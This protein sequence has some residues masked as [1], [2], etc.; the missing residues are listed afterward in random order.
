MV[1]GFIGALIS[2]VVL[3]AAGGV[4][5]A[6]FGTNEPVYTEYVE[7]LE[8]FGEN[9]RLLDES[10]TGERTWNFDGVDEIREVEVTSSG[11]KTYIE[12]SKNGKLQVT[13][14]S[15]GWNELSVE[16]EYTPG[17]SLRLSVSRVGIGLGS[18]GTVTICVP[19][20][21]YERMTIAVG[22][23]T[24]EARDIKARHNEF[25]VSS[26]S[27]EFAQSPRFTADEL[28]LDLGSGSVSIA[29]AAT[30]LYDVNMGSG[31]FD[32]SGLTGDGAVYIGSGSGTVE[33][34]KLEMSHNL[35]ELGSGSLKVYIPNDTKADLYTSFGSGS[36]YID[37]CGVSERVT[38]DRQIKLNGGSNDLVSLHAE[39][40]SGRLEL[41]DSSE[42]SSPNMFADFPAA[43][44]M[45]G[46]VVTDNDNASG[47]VS[48]DTN[49]AEVTTQ[50]SVMPSDGDS[51]AMV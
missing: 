50:S 12:P 9:G 16:V 22:S 41:R 5:V 30:T 45:P 2:A 32:I 38:D 35:F 4:T 34:A 48:A 7:D 25:N 15:S 1:K 47:F 49:I 20:A 40:G 23:G 44:T 28:K 18:G 43:Q 14:Q 21:V 10:F 24:L 3:F 42:Y 26:G 13:G 33:F 11:V 31:N 19:D 51:L 39:L 36:V 6:I 27:F 37:C 46:E 8:W 29:N 17:E